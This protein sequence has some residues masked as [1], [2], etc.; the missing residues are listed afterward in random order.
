MGTNASEEDRKGRLKR[1]ERA[2]KKERET[3]N[4][5]LKLP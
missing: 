5:C 1:G 4:V 3:F 2:F